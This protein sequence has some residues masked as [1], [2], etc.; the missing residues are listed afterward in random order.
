MVWFFVLGC[1]V[2]GQQGGQS[3]DSWQ[4]IESDT[5]IK[6]SATKEMTLPEGDAPCRAPVE[7]TVQMVFDGDTVRMKPVSGGIAEDVRFIGVD[8]PEIAHG[9]DAADCW[10]ENAKEYTAQNLYNQVWLTFDSECVDAYGRTLAYV[11]QGENGAEFF[12]LSLVKNGH[13][14]VLTIS[15]NDTFAPDFMKAEATARQED[16]GLWGVC[17]G[18]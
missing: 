11:H 13:A 2:M 3:P 10:G 6:D 4:Y 16:L 7:M 1:H 14:R 18:S 8:T 17:E 5:S 9:M 15:P 12:N